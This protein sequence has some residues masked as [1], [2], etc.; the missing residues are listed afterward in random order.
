MLVADLITANNKYN[1]FNIA[2]SGNG[3]FL[4]LTDQSSKQASLLQELTLQ[5]LQ[6]ENYSEDQ[7]LEPLFLNITVGNPTLPNSNSLLP[8][9]I[10]F[11]K[12][13]VRAENKHTNN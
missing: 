12:A 5:K 6:I 13:I 2:Y 1:S 8:N 4:A 7:N 11:S 10:I 9:D 3:I